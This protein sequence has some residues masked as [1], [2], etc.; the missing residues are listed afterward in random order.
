MSDA[1]D[2]TPFPPALAIVGPTAVGKSES[3]IRIAEAVGG[4]IISADSRQFYRGMDIGTAKV[5]AEEQA[6]VPH[7]MIDICDPHEALTLA[8]FQ[9]QSYAQMAQISTRGKLPM[10]VGGTGLYL[11]AVIEGYGIPRVP[12]H[13][14]LRASLFDVA[15]REGHA[16]LHARL[17]A[18]DAEAAARIDSRNVRRVVRALEVYELSGTPISVLQRKRPPPYRFLT[19][20]LTRPRESLY[21]RV[22]Q[23]IARML[24]LGFIAE[25]QRLLAAG[26]AADSEAM[27]A[28]GYREC[29]AFLKGEIDD[30]A[31]LAAAIGQSTR[32]F[33]RGQANWFRK[34]DP[35]IR[36]FDLDKERVEAILTFVQAWLT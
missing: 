26:I 27:T 21:A 6:R 36:W 30:E 33:I 2:A 5:S 20:G 31:A 29:V 32:R 4:E 28:L 9:A 1:L 23:R 24:A 35:R 19:I 10:L 16:A 25:T 13:D 18:V 15:D 8:D 22:D 14:E 34:S 7:H 11:K 17:A 12:P 3:A